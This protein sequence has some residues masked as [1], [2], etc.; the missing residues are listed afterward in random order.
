MS[1]SV[2]PRPRARPVLLVAGGWYATVAVA[3]VVGVASM[4]APGPSD[5]APRTTCGSPMFVVLAVGF[6][7]LLVAS[8]G[9]ALAGW[10]LTTWAPATRA[11]RSV[12]VAGTVAAGLGVAAVVLILAL[13]AVVRR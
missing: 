13:V 10:A 2:A 5:C 8:A 12:V 9:A 6:P 1:A 11:L 7:L 3:V 4:P